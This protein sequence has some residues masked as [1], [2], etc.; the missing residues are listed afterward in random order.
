MEPTRLTGN[1][2]LILTLW[3]SIFLVPAEGRAVL[4]VANEKMKSL[5]IESLFCLHSDSRF[6]YNLPDRGY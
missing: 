1:Y 6:C 4:S 2:L 5:A 3:L